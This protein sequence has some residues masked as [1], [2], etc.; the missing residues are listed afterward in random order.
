MMI[1]GVWCDNVTCKQCRHRHPVGVSCEYAKAIAEAG[2]AERRRA[3]ETEAR[4]VDP[5]VAAQEAF[6]LSTRRGSEFVPLPDG[7]GE[8]K[9]A[10][11]FNGVLFIACD[12][13]AYYRSKEGTWQE[14]KL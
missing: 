1:E 13:G 7:A 8:F 5:L 9:A 12:N 10:T 2:R 14:L 6:T 4:R 11:V 3:E